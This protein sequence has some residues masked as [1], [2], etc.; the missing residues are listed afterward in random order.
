M[1]VDKGIDAL[2]QLGAVDNGPSDLGIFLEDGVEGTA[3]RPERE[4]FVLKRTH[5]CPEI[6]FLVDVFLNIFLE[7]GGALEAPTGILRVRF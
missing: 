6:K 7:Q 5:Q 3:I 2:V 4:F 1:G